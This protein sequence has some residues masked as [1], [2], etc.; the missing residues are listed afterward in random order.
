MSLSLPSSTYH[1]FLTSSIHI[2]TLQILASLLLTLMLLW[3]ISTT[4]LVE[5]YQMPRWWVDDFLAELASAWRVGVWVGVGV[6]VPVDCAVALVV[7]DWG[8]SEGGGGS[9]DSNVDCDERKDDERKDDERTDD[10]RTHMSTVARQSPNTSHSTH[11]N[12]ISP[13][14]HT[15]HPR[16]SPSTLL[17][18]LTSFDI[19]ILSI[20][21]AHIAT[22]L[23]SLPTALALCNTPAVLAYPDW[24]FGATNVVLG[25]RDRCI[26]LNVD[27]H[28]AGGFAV[29]MAVVLGLLHLAALGVRGWGVVRLGWG[30]VL[31]RR[32]SVDGKWEV[33]M[34]GRSGEK[35]A[36]VSTA[37]R[38]SMPRI[39]GAASSIDSHI[40]TSVGAEERGT[41]IGFVDWRTE[42]TERA[43]RRGADTA[44]ESEGSPAKWSEVFLECLIDG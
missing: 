3:H 7:V 5:N 25:M 6:L 31:T 21:T 27:I 39:D 22:Y 33:E 41:G 36:R 11:S 2:A 8:S 30:G 16:C 40:A 17:T 15:H 35:S 12:P 44:R 43:E 29:F 28:V 20:L 4:T 18:L 19:L 37:S 14:L 26:G 10:E 38:R 1:H 13:R 42:C 34:R 32:R 24:E 9:G 23:I